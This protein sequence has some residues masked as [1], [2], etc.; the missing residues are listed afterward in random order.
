MT[1]NQSKRIGGNTT[2]NVTINARDTSDN[3][4]RRIADKIGR[5]INNKINR[6]VGASSLR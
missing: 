6:N 1:N 5:M 4:M 2:I 3:E